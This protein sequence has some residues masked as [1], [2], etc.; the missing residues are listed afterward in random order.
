MTM[1][2]LAERA[3]SPYQP[4]APV[5]LALAAGLE[6]TAIRLA[7]L[8]GQRD[9]NVLANLVFFH[10]HPERAGRALRPDEPGFADLS[11]EWLAIRDTAAQGE[12]GDQRD[13][14]AQGGDAK[15]N[16]ES[17]MCLHEA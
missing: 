13:R 14:A 16:L 5:R 15:H 10:R 9:A 11:R 6:R 4:P 3:R 1:T 17:P 2:A 7:A 8:W 12:R